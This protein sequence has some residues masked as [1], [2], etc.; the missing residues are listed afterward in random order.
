MRTRIIFLAVL[1]VSVPVCW[2]FGTSI[3]TDSQSVEKKSAVGTA[4]SNK[5]PDPDLAPVSRE[6]MMTEIG[7][8]EGMPQEEQ[9]QRILE[10]Y[11][12]HKAQSSRPLSRVEKAILS[13]FTRF[14]EL[15]NAVGK[16]L[17]NEFSWPIS[18]YG[19]V[20]D[21]RTNPVAQAEISFG[22]N[23]MS[24]SRSTN[25]SS[26]INGLF[27][28]AGVTGNGLSVHV[29]KSGYYTPKGQETYFAYSKGYRAYP[30]TP[31]IFRLRKQGTG[32]ELITSQTGVSEYVDIR[33]PLDGIPIRV[34]FFNRTAGSQGQLEFSNVKPRLSFD[35]NPRGI[36]VGPDGQK[37]ELPEWSFH[38]SI[39]EGGFVEHNDEFP[40]QAPEAGYQPT[41]D[42]HFKA[43]ATNWTDQLQKQY[44][45]AFG[46]PRKYGRI[47]FE[48][49]MY[50][51]VRLRYAINPDGTRN[52][53]SK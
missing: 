10:W 14:E 20:V 48:T 35:G 32:V 22:W 9:R 5:V 39:P 47:R 34:D 38:L 29:S 40:F 28:L 43:G 24:G 36:P 11:Q 7:I 21:E 52:L 23:T 30:S 6:E 12:A 1:L 18:F 45:I 19:Q 37:M 25:T 31:A 15:K 16:S 44:Y 46:Q 17:E 41:L 50:Q 3:F 4:P 42:F 27:S 33:V 2:F 26:D 13:E 49:G 53:E 8:S 51:G